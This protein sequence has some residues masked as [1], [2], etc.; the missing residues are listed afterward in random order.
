MKSIEFK[1]RVV[2]QDKRIAS[3]LEN[4]ENNG[5]ATVAAGSSSSSHAPDGNGGDRCFSSKDMVS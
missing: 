5:T 1:V 2:P 3:T 4:L